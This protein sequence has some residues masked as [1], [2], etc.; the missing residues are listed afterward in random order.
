MNT[1]N[2]ASGMKQET[3]CIRLVIVGREQKYLTQ[4]PKCSEPHLLRLLVLQASDCF[5]QCLHHQVAASQ[6]YWQGCQTLARLIDAHRS[7]LYRHLGMSR[8]T[9]TRATG[10]MLSAYHL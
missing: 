5:K 9:C 2:T 10:D 8:S 4:P 7:L 6:L 1:S 3:K